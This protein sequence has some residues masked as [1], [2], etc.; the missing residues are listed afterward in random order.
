MIKFDGLAQNTYCR[1]DIP[2]AM[3]VPAL[4]ISLNKAAAA[5]RWVP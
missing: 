2:E 3:L 5:P 1:Y 4:F